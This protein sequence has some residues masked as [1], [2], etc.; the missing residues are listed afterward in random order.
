[1]TAVTGFVAQFEHTALLDHHAA[2]EGEADAAASLLGGEE[3]N[4]KR[5]AIL[6][7]DGGTIIAD[8]E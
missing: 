3:R 8:V 4:D 7:R 1:M 2:A 5:L 6:G